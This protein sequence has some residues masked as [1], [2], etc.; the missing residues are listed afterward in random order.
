MRRDG[1]AT[2]IRTQL[3]IDGPSRRASGG[4]SLARPVP[5]GFEI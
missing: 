2:L 1:L 3:Y 5:A 4:L